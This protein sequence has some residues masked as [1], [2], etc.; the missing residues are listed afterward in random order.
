[1][2]VFFFIIIML[3]IYKSQSLSLKFTNALIKTANLRKNLSSTTVFNENTNVSLSDHKKINLNISTNSNID[4]FVS[5]DLVIIPVH[6]P[7]TLTPSTISNN[8]DIEKIFFDTLNPSLKSLAKDLIGTKNNNLKASTSV[9]FSL[10]SSDNLPKSIHLLPISA[11]QDF[12]KFFSSTN[13][14]YKFGKKIAAISKQSHSKNISLVL[15][16]LEETTSAISPIDS[17]LIGVQEGVTIE[18]DRYKGED[19]KKKFEKNPLESLTLISNSSNLKVSD[20]S[21]SISSGV[22]LARDIVSA[23]PNQKTPIGIAKVARD[24]VAK[25][26]ESLSIKILNKKECEEL[27]MGGYL[28]V[29]QGSKYEPQFIHITFN[30]K[31]SSPDAKK[32]KIAFVGKGLTFDSGGYNL[33]AGSASMIELMKFD[34]GGLGAVLGSVQSISELNKLNILSDDLEIHFISAVC[35]NMISSEAMKPGDIVYTSNGKSVEIL[36]TDAEGRLTLADAL[37]Y[38]EKLKPEVI[39]DLATLTGACIVGLGENLAGLYSNN[40]ELSKLLVDSG[41]TTGMYSIL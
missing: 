14:L 20:I 1:M 28:A 40:E 18:D 5:S 11:S 27:N 39:I 12:K 29:Q 22:S 33:K 26:P 13:D 32:K 38:A 36:N 16:N 35:E 4:S 8:E 25:Y 37:V 31:S 3:G 23:P 6:L 24:L 19:N 41:K 2:K 10:F 7:S 30:S 9:T 21:S 15:P 34:C 17:L